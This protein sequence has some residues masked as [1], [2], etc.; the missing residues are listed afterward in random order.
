[1]RDDQLYSDQEVVLE[2]NPKLLGEKPLNVDKFIIKIQPDAN[3]QMMTLSGG[4]IDV[5]MNMTDDTMSELEGA[6]NIPL[7]TEQNQDSWICDDEHG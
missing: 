1:M 4:D 5:A 3:T 7:S 2:K 6:E